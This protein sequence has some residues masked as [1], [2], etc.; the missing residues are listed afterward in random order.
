MNEW[1][2]VGKTDYFVWDAVWTKDIRR[3][4]GVGPP[5]AWYLVVAVIVLNKDSKAMTIPAFDLLDTEGTKYE[6]TSHY[7][8]STRLNPNV[9]G[10]IVLAFD[11]PRDRKYRL[12][13]F[14]SESANLWRLIDIKG[15]DDNDIRPANR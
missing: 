4:F 15:T 2:T 9:Q 12:K 3:Y 14:G 8:L 6:M 13:A 10:R 11:V 7:A 1:V 5:H